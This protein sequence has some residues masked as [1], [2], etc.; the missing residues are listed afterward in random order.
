MATAAS[1]SSSALFSVFE[2]T[3]FSK[4]QTLTSRPNPQVFRT[5]L[6]RSNR[7][8][9]S[10][11]ICASVSATPAVRTRPDDLVAS[12]LSK[13][14]QT[15]RGVLLSSEEHKEVAE[16]AQELQKYCVEKP[17]QCPLI[18]GEWDVVY[19]S[20]PTSPGGGYRSAIGRLVFKTKEMIQVV[21]A[22]DTVRNKVSFSALGFIDGEVSLKG[23]LKALDHK[24]I[25]V[26]FEPPELKVGPWNFRYGGESE[27]KLEITYIDEKIRLGKGSKG[28]LFV[29]ERCKQA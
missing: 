3:R 5:V 27:V 17:V 1:P 26:V 16:L 8:L 29:F 4:L 9:K 11:R 14:T 23:K 28:S 2:A 7:H 22:P 13:V 10:Q 24:W 15:D 20:V 12:I 19:C 18:F 21:D 25:Q 6:L